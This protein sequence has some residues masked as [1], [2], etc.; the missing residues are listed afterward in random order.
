MEVFIEVATFPQGDPKVRCTH[1]H[2]LLKHSILNRG[3][4]KSISTYTETT[5]C[6]LD[7]K[8]KGVLSSKR[9]IKDFLENRT[10]Y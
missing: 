10:V 1:C 3:G 6:G 5:K 7:K 2:V 4:T 9:S 8:G